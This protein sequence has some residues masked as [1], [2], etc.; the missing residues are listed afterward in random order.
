RPRGGA[1]KLA[2]NP[3]VQAFEDQSLAD[4]RDAIRSG[5]ADLRVLNG[6]IQRFGF[7]PADAFRVRSSTDLRGLA[8]LLSDS[9]TDARER[10]R[11]KLR[12]RARSAL[13][14][15]RDQPAKLDAVRMGLDLLR[16][17]RKL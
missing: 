2:G 16:F 6:L 5:R 1:V 3:M 15:H 10:R 17:R 8:D 9:R 13:L 7:V 11:Q 12:D 4:R 14:Q